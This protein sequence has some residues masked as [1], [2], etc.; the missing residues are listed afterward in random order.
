M[1]CFL[2]L[3]LTF[4]HIFCVFGHL[5]AQI[6]NKFEEKKTKKNQKIIEYHHISNTNS[7]IKMNVLCLL[8]NVMWITMRLISFNHNECWFFG[9][10][11]ASQQT[12]IQCSWNW[13][14]WKNTKLRE[15]EIQLR[16]MK[17]RGRRK[18]KEKWNELKLKIEDQRKMK[19][20]GFRWRQQH[21]I[22]GADLCVH[23]WLWCRQYCCW[24]V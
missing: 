13:K 10:S 15:S 17:R 23:V 11:D 1:W 12:H 20:D 8:K 14:R 9:D 22:K 7:E 21:N 3:L 5:F 4:S 6:V 19:G 24:C 2:I 18:L 16:R